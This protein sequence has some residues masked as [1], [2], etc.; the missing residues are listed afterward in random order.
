MI[1]RHARSRGPWASE[2]GLDDEVLA[3][4]GGRPTSAGTG[5]GFP[6]SSR[7]RTSRCARASSQLAEFLE[8]AHR[9]DGGDAAL[10]LRAAALRQAV[11]PRSRDIVTADVEKVFHGLDELGSWDAV[12][13]SEP[14]LAARSR[15][16][17]RRGAGGDRPL[18]RPEVAVHARATRKRSPTLAPRPRARPG[19]PRRGAARCAGPAWCTTWAGS[20]CRT[21]SGTSP[22]R[23]AQASGS[24]SACTRYLTER[25]LHRLGGARP[26]RA[27]SP[28]STGSGSTVPATRGACRRRAH[29]G[30]PDPG[31]RRRLP[32]DDA[33]PGR[34]GRAHPP[35]SRGRARDEVRAGR[36]DGAAVDAVLPP[37]GTACGRRRDRPGRSHRPR[38]RGAAP[39]GPGPVEQGDR[40][41]G[42]SITPKTVGNHVEHIYA[43]IGVGNRAA[44]S[45]FAM[46]HGLVPES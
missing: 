36:L 28:C 12:I 38:G 34:T 44:A 24:G 20:A 25:M 16:R 35:T 32:G 18:R 21:R 17:V 43:K 42:W 4:L 8:V 1:A 9:T 31:R 45:L 23:S 39:A 3:A 13:D 15:R 37:P 30:R 2:L 41:R 14:S 6:A 27:G 40:R 29:P 10:E 46:R 5:E 19:L 26:A 22:A 33:S 7:A 11:R